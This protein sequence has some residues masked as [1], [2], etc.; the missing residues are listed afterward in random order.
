MWGGLLIV[1]FNKKG[2]SK[3]LVRSLKQR[4]SNLWYWGSH[5]NDSSDI[6]LEAA[7]AVISEV[8]VTHLMDV[9]NKIQVLHGEMEKISTF[10]AHEL[11]H[12]SYNIFQEE[13]DQCHWDS[14]LIIGEELLGFLMKVSKI[15]H[16][17]PF[18]IKNIVQ[19]FMISF[20]E[21]Q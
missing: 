2:S 20:C 1:G 6:F 19:I 7:Q 14:Q 15:D 18:L 5:G 16:I 13:L 21:S 17:N 9:V 10:L 11:W 8:G 4:F 12:D 3:T